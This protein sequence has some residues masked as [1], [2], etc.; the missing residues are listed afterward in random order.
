MARHLHPN[1]IGPRQLMLSEDEGDR[2]GQEGEGKGEYQA[3]M[4]WGGGVMTQGDE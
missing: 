2:D 4:Y 1:H 3:C